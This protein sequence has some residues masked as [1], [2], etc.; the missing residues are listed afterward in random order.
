MTNI[1]HARIAFFIDQL[2]IVNGV[3]VKHIVCVISY[4]CHRETRDIKFQFLSDV[5]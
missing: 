2:I 4:L 1:N 3:I 5:K